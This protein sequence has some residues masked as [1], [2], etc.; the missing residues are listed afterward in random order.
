[1]NWRKNHIKGSQTLTGS[2]LK[3]TKE[4]RVRINQRFFQDVQPSPANQNA[5]KNLVNNK[6][7]VT[8]KKI[9]LKEGE[10]KRVHLL[11]I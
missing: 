6:M 9:I 1:M 10:N 3:K 11:M 2:F 4:V 8:K 5:I 7:L